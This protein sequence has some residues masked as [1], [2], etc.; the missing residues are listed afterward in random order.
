MYRRY[1]SE[2]RSKILAAA[3]AARAKGGT[4]NDALVAAKE[5]GYSSSSM[6]LQRLVKKRTGRRVGRP[7]G[8]K[9]KPKPAGSPFSEIGSLVENMANE[10]ALQILDNVFAVAK[11]RLRRKVRAFA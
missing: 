6:A 3:L 8:S 10:R 5:H 9:N 11:S 7:A 4:W 2:R 1:D